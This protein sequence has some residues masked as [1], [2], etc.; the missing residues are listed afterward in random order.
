[1]KTITVKQLK[2]N[3]ACEDQVKLFQ[4]TFGDTL[5]LKSKDHALKLAKAMVNKFDFDWAA[6]NLLN[7][8]K[9]Y[10]EAREPLLK[11]YEEARAPLYKAHEEAEEP[12]Y[13]AYREDIVPLLK[14]YME[15]RAPSY[16]AYEEAG[17]QLFAEM[18]WDQE[19]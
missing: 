19:G 6:W 9:A 8:F 11:A 14:A 7:D 18:Y 10:E 13:E 2:A 15:A 17:A 3:D 16:K 12:L 5:E 4:E 1:M